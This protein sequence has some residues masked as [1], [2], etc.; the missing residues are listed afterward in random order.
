MSKKNANQPPNTIRQ[1]DVLLVEVDSIP[2]SAKVVKPTDRGIVFAEGAV[3]GHAHRIP[4]RHAGGAQHY[5]TETD[6]QYMRATAPVPLRHEEH[7]TICAECPRMPPSIATHR[8]SNGYAREDYRCEAHANASGMP[9]TALA[10]PGATVLP[11]SKRIVVIHA[12]YEPGE[13]VR[14]VED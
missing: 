3:T 13:L 7:K 5:R 11:P 10:E 6:A 4:R 14:Q 12:E 1:G 2:E 8:L 9:V